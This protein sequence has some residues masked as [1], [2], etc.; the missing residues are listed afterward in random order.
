MSA[1]LNITTAIRQ[2]GWNPQ[3]EPLAH[4]R[5]RVWDA[6]GSHLCDRSQGFWDTHGRSLCDRGCSIQVREDRGVHG[7]F[8]VHQHHLPQALHYRS[9]R[10]SALDQSHQNTQHQGDSSAWRPGSPDTS[11]V[12]ASLFTVHSGR[13]MCS[14]PPL[15]GLFQ[16]HM[17]WKSKW[18]WV[19]ISGC[20]MSL[21]IINEVLFC[22]SF[23]VFLYYPWRVRGRWLVSH[24]SQPLQRK[25]I[26]SCKN[27]IVFLIN[28]LIKPYLPSKDLSCMTFFNCI[29]TKKI[30][31]RYSGFRFTDFL[32]SKKETFSN[33]ISMQWPMKWANVSMTTK[34]TTGK[35]ES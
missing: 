13:P 8:Q 27:L 28:K 12:P 24:V 21:L 34:Q 4:H 7:G 22:V 16:G 23:V 9:P 26:N 11:T 3:L 19:I 31:S 6:Y 25:R 5:W 33:N 15:L 10:Y 32:E 18:W 35:T 14:P 17:H 30:F 29:I 1:Y 20:L 2:P